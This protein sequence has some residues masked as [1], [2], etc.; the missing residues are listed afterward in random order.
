MS[1]IEELR[2]RVKDLE[3]KIE[4]LRLGRRV[5]MNIIESIERE[6]REEI[7]RLTRENQRLLR[8]NARFAKSLFESNLRLMESRQMEN[9]NAVQEESR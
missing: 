8:S 7:E 5:L 1:E 9:Q 6:R 2:Q 4:G 3:Q